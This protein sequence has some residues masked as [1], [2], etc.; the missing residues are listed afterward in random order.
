MGLTW[1]GDARQ[2]FKDKQ[3]V[4]RMRQKALWHEDSGCDSRSQGRKKAGLPGAREG[5]EP[6]PRLPHP[7]VPLLLPLPRAGSVLPPSERGKRPPQSAH[8]TQPG[9]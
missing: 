1:G 6:A 9:S 8:N 2:V 7:P 3:Q 5:T 4:N